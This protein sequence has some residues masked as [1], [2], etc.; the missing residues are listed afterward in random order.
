MKHAWRVRDGRGPEYTLWRDELGDSLARI[1]LTLDD[2]NEE[3]PAPPATQTAGHTTLWIAAT[4]QYQREG[5]ALFD[6]VRPSPRH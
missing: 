3:P 4:L 5:T 2:I 6:L 1:G